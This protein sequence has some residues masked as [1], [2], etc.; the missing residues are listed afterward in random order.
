M[1]GQNAKTPTRQ[2]AF[3][4]LDKTTIATAT[5]FAFSSA[6]RDA[7]FLDARLVARALWGRLVYKYLGADHDRMETMRNSALRL[8]KGWEQ[9]QIT[10][11]VTNVM[12]E[13][14]DPIV[15]REALEEIAAHKAAGHLVF[16]VSASPE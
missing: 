10:Q 6:L 16:M 9:R 3:F 7:G 8:A 1:A 2:A 12:E 14:I 4:D 11:L 5:M 13:T 15:Y